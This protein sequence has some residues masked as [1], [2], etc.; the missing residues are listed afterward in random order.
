M[1]RF[2][3]FSAALVCA[4]AGGA[5]AQR[6]SCP[7]GTAP[8]TQTTSHQG[9]IQYGPVRGCYTYTQTHQSCQPVPKPTPPPAS[10]PKK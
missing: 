10:G 4:L 2:I 3:A 7:P 1:F 8:Q 6:P 5:H 9:C